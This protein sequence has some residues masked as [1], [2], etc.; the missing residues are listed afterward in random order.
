MSSVCCCFFNFIIAS[1]W[2]SVHRKSTVKFMFGGGATSIVNL[3]LTYHMLGAEDIGH[4]VNVDRFAHAAVSCCSSCA[5]CECCTDDDASHTR[6]LIACTG[7]PIIFD[8]A[9]E[10]SSSTTASAAVLSDRPSL[11]RNKSI[12]LDSFVSAAAAVGAQVPVP[13]DAASSADGVCESPL[14]GDYI[15]D[16]SK[17]I[18]SPSRHADEDAANVDGDVSDADMKRAVARQTGHVPMVATCLI[19]RPLCFRTSTLNRI[20]DALAYKVLMV[21]SGAFLVG[22]F[23]VRNSPVVRR[24]CIR[25]VVVHTSCAH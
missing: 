20:V 2:H 10:Q 8:K 7:A 16:A 15:A 22:V 6:Y 18:S 4:P 12:E 5:G 9:T 17:T 13:V 21:L 24:S 19:Y 1:T 25:V 3:D 14:T 23:F 11:Y